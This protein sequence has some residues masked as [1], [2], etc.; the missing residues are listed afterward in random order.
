MIVA[1]HRRRTF[2]GRPVHVCTVSRVTQAPCGLP[3]VLRMMVSSPRQQQQQ[4]PKLTSVWLE[5]Q[6]T[7]IN[8]T[9]QCATSTV[10]PQT[11]PYLQQSALGARQL[12]TA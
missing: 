10:A 6:V 11:L 9:E 4:Q 2:Y 3:A 7:V 8:Q 5:M 1:A 12:P